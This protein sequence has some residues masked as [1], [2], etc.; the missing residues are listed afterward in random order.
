[1]SL[2]T[3][4]S[5]RHPDLPHLESTWT[6][7]PL[8]LPA[9]LS[10]WDILALAFKWKFPLLI[11]FL[12]PLAGSIALINVLPPTY[13][14][15]TSLVVG[16]GPEYLA[17]S[18]GSAAM[19]APTSTKQEFIN[20]EIELLNSLAVAKSTI[21]RV[22]LEHIYPEILTSPP[23]TGT[24]LDAA[25]VVFKSAI[26]VDLVKLS[27]LI[28]VSFD[29]KDPQTASKVLDQFINSYEEL[30]ANV[31]SSRRARSYEE[32]IARDTMELEKLERERAAVKAAGNIY[33][34]AQQRSVLIMYRVDAQKRL[35]ETIDALTRIQDR[36][37]YLTRERPRLSSE[38]RSVQT[39]PR[40]ETVHARQMLFDLQQKEI[41]LLGTYNPNSPLVQRVRTQIETLQ[42]VMQHME[43]TFTRVTTSASPITTAIDQEMINS[44]AELT[45]LLAQKDRYEA[46]VKSI[47]DQLQH[48]ELG[49]SQLRILDAHIDAQNDNL[50]A[51]RKLYDQARAEDEMELAKVTSVVQTSKAITLEKPVSPNK[52]LLL[53]AGTI[54]GF[55]AAAGVVLIAVITNR[56]FLSEGSVERFLGLPVLGSV[57]LRRPEYQQRLA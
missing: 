21:E 52:L 4:L 13:R 33:D 57:P 46:I 36:L 44:R 35:H 20:T 51:M 49:D 7:S 27:N 5:G 26:H 43:D 47:E 41:T 9:V 24:A 42:R 30:H 50:K 29:H 34:L 8:S 45:P 15:Q 6:I 18:D 12:F 28:N 11:A 38:L 16:I 22:G 3:A 48:I 40:A 53:V 54:T 19:T 25:V 2:P 39:D 17:Q 37:A 14:A 23:A 32:T 1:M 56:T 10:F 55:I 31:F